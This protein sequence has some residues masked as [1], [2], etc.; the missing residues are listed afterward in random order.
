MKMIPSLL[1]TALLAIGTPV[2]AEK[3][4]GVDVPD[5]ITVAETSL[6]LNGAGVRKKFFMDIYIAG[7]YLPAKTTDSAAILSDKGPASVW[8]YILYDKISKEK[9]TD[10]WTDGMRANLPE[11]E[12]QE[13]DPVLESFNKLFMAVHKGDVIQIDYLPGKGTEV[14]INN[15]WRGIVGDNRFFRALL[16][17]WLGP[18]PVTKEI[19]AAMLGQQ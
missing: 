9:I 17:V 10:G 8:M 3:I 18:K 19:K 11:N 5:S 16:N 12:I 7:L 2:H 14:R 13:L 6:A 15:E 1:L 4:S